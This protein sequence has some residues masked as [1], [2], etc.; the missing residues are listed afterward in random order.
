MPAAVPLGYSVLPRKRPRSEA[1]GCL[2]RRRLARW[3]SVL[4]LHIDPAFV[5]AEDT[6]THPPAADQIADQVG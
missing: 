3:R 6:F 1:I 4:V 2:C 5:K